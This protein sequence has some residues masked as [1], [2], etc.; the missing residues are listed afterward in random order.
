MAISPAIYGFEVAEVSTGDTVPVKWGTLEG[1]TCHDINIE[2]DPIDGGFVASVPS[3]PG[4]HAQ[5]ETLGEVLDNI[6]TAIIEWQAL[7]T[8]LQ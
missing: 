7:T 4:C 1:N 5:G 8:P 2:A 6:R 3:M